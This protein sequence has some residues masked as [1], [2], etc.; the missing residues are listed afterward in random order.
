MSFVPGL[1]LLVG[2]MTD[3]LDR[4]EP[5]AGPRVIVVTGA[6][7]GIGRAVALEAATAGHHLVLAARGDRSLEE[8]RLECTER[9]ALSA[10]AVATDVGEDDEVAALVQRALDRHRSEEHTS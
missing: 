9:G 3:R 5:A 10:L 6:S 7:S 1:G 4:R 8:V 2:R